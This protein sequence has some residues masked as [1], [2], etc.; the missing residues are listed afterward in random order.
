MLL[1]VVAAGSPGVMTAAGYGSPS[2]LLIFLPGTAS[3]A[4]PGTA[5]VD[6]PFEIDVWIA[7]AGR[8]LVKDGTSALVTLAVDPGAEPRPALTC[9]GG[10]AVR[11]NTTGPN[12]GLA[13]FTGCTFDREGD[14]TLS[15]SASDVASTVV[16]TPTIAPQVAAPLHVL[17][18]VEAPQEAITLT[19]DGTGNPYVVLPYGRSATLRVAFTEHGANQPFQL[20]EGSRT[21]STWRA[22]ADLTTGDDGTATI[23]V[24]PSVSAWYRVIYRGSPELAAGRSRLFTALVQAVASQRPVN[25]TPRVIARGTTVRF[26]TRVRPVIAGLAPMKVGF[27]LYHRIG[28]T[29]RLASLRTRAVDAAGVARINITFAAPG[30]WYVRSYAK[31]QLARNVPVNPDGVLAA[32]GGSEP[33][34][35]ARF[36]VH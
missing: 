27:Q 15:A 17:P 24:R 35:I 34:S 8:Q 7:D 14:V 6:H 3:E 19:L 32:I 26:T 4:F 2:R 18:S 29:W 36:R 11:T 13:A 25:G 23:A 9:P 30:D 22:V 21:S 5:Y 10:L 16:P 28:G 33:T 31:G 20:Q 1:T 12:A